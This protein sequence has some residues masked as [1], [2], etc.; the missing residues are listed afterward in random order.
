[1]ALKMGSGVEPVE[2]YRYKSQIKF[3]TLGENLKSTN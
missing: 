1:M 2:Y 3:Q